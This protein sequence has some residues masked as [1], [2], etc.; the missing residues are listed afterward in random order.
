MIADPKRVRQVL[1]NLISNA[2]KYSS[3]GTIT[4]SL[5]RKGKQVEVGMS[6]ETALPYAPPSRYG[7]I[8]GTV[9]AVR[10]FVT[11]DRLAESMGSQALAEAF[12]GG[13]EATLEIEVTFETDP[14][15]ISGLAWTSV[16]GYPRPIP[17]LSLCSVRVQLRDDRPIELVIPWLKNMA[18]VDQ[19]PVEH[20][21]VRR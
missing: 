17:G 6:A 11:D 7:Y 20:V 3:Q 9:T 10:N 8:K 15:T 2:I 13:N 14:T 1:N 16:G 5:E 18:G 21:G 12:T 4:L 19:P